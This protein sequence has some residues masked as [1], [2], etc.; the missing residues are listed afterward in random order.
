MIS[1]NMMALATTLK[2]ISYFFVVAE[3]NS[4]LAV[5]SAKNLKLEDRDRHFRDYR[6]TADNY[7]YLLAHREDFASLVSLRSFAEFL[8]MPTLC[9]QLTYPRTDRI[10]PK[11]LLKNSLFFVISM[12]LML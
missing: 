10:R 2:L 1:L 8:F 12:M 9:F 6:V 7:E 5:V 4:I 3:V 11:F